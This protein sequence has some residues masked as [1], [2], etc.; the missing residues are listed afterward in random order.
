VQKP[1]RVAGF[2]KPGR[3]ESKDYAVIRIA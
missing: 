2:V 1:E 3:R